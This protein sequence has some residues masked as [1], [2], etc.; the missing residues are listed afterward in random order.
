MRHMPTVATPRCTPPDLSTGGR[1]VHPG[2]HDAP[3]AT[4]RRRRGFAAT[5]AT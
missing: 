4:G 5:D 1:P 2:S 3:P